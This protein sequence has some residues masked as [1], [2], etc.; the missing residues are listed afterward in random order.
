MTE[1]TPSTTV[2]EA[3]EQPPPKVMVGTDVQ[4][5]PALEMAI[6]WTAPELTVASPIAAP[7]QFEEP[8]TRVASLA[9]QPLPPA[10][11]VMA[12]MPSDAVPAAL[13]PLPPLKAIVGAEV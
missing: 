12:T 8:M 6:D 11:M 4:P 2:A 3:P 10:P 13:L 1:T 5:E 9:V 7:L